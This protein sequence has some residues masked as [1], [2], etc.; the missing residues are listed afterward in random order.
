MPVFRYAD[1]PQVGCT[2]NFPTGLISRPERRARTPVQTSAYECRRDAYR[3]QTSTPQRHPRGH[4][5]RRP[6]KRRAAQRRRLVSAA[7]EQPDHEIRIEMIPSAPTLGLA[8]Q[9]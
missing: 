8:Q 7:G 9:P 3:M 1:V 6:P 2:P 5:S 4:E